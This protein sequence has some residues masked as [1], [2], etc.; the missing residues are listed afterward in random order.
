MPRGRGI[1]YRPRSIGRGPVSRRVLTPRCAGKGKKSI[2]LC[3]SNPSCTDS[4]FERKGRKK[5]PAIKSRVEA[6]SWSGER[7]SGKGVIRRTT[8]GAAGKKGQTG[9]RAALRGE[10]RE[11][12]YDLSGGKP[13]V[14]LTTKQVRSVLDQ[15]GASAEGTGSSEDNLPPTQIQG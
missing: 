5:N 3:F 1:A 7:T 9:Q 12:E 10:R 6:G 11:E 15:P 2:N 14:L 8:S 13:L 4:S